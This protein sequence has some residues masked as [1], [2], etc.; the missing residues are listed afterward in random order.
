MKNIVITGANGFIAKNVISILSLNYDY[1][2]IKITRDDDSN[3]IK[4][5]L[6]NTDVLLH[7]AGVN[8][9]TKLNHLESDNVLYTKFIFDELLNNKQKCL[10][11]MSSSIQALL[12]NDYGISKKNAEDYVTKRT[13]GTMVSSY[14]YRLPGIFGKGCNPNYNSVVA[15]FCY[16]ISNGLPIVINN[17]ETILNLIY[18]ESFAKDLISLFNYEIFEGKVILKEFANVNKVKLI[19]LANKIIY[20]RD[21]ILDNSTP[22]LNNKFEKDLYDTFISYLPKNSNLYNLKK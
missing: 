22:Q 9:P 20:F 16:N 7:F 19:D 21:S 10:F 8:R 3:S 5:K 13:I 1:N 12:N 4:S 15:T 6:K 18:V 2:L 17:P 14:I 11:I